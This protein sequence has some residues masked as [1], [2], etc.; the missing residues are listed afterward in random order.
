MKA[1]K[2]AVLAGAAFLMMASLAACGKDKKT[3]NE[4]DLKDMTFEAETV[5]L[6]G[7][8]GDAKEIEIMGDRLYL[9]TSQYTDTT[10]YPDDWVDG[11][12]PEGADESVW[13]GIE[14]TSVVKDSL[15]S[16]ATDGTDVK[17]L[18]T[19]EADSE[20]DGDIRSITPTASGEVIVLYARYSDS[21]GSNEFNM[22]VY[23][24]NGKKQSELSLSDLVDPEEY[25][26]G[27][28]TD[29]EDRIYLKCDQK[30]VV[31]DQEGKQLF[32]VD[33]TNYVSDIIKDKN[34]DVMVHYYEEGESQLK[35]IDVQKKG[36]GELVEAGSRV[37][38]IYGGGGDYDY[39][40]DD[41]S[42]LIGYSADGKQKTLLNWVGSNIVPNDISYLTAI[43][44]DHFAAWS[45]DEE[46]GENGSFILLKKVD[47]SK[48]GDQTAIVFGGLYL[49]DTLKKQAIK[50]NK[51]QNKYRIVL[52]DYSGEDDPEGRMNAD[53]LAGDVP[54]IL[55]LSSSPVD[56][57]ISKGMLLDLYTLIDKDPDLSR[58]DFI[59][60]ILKT[61]EVDGKL[62]YISPTFSISTLA[63]SKED[64]GD[65]KSLSIDEIKEL[66]EKHKGAKAFHS[67]Y[68]NNQVLEMLCSNNYDT[69][70][71]WKTG[72]CSF[73][74]EEFVKILEYAATYPDE[75][76]VNYDEDTDVLQDIR[77]GKTLFMQTYNMSFEDVEMYD[78]IF[79][80][81]VSFI[82]L[83]SA[84]KGIGV[85]ISS[86][87]G[88]YAK[89]PN[90]EG[91]WDFYKTLL[92]R[93]YVNSPNIYLSGLPLRKDAY[94]DA[95]KK[96]TA[97]KAYTDDFGNEIEPYNSSWGFESL[98]IDIKPLSEEQVQMMRDV[99]DAADHRVV[100][101]MEVTDI[102]TEEAGAYF[103]GAKSAKETADIIQNRI[104]TYVNENR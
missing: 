54:D 4:I 62:Y 83:P 58:D 96:A 66:E 46:L 86:L 76:K 78:Q 69:F 37:S 84:D 2:K 64:V 74:N 80:Q 50:Y 75:D 52:R 60:N 85:N 48:V 20:K 70:I 93:E 63:A 94:E 91:A 11:E 82:G 59:D 17:E 49:D 9:H 38:S 45:R 27:L 101:N 5:N 95:E 102:I 6:D 14:Y 57:Y 10:D 77:D 79:D 8:E 26:T 43:D 23:D 53:I 24:Q 61:L 44:N 99:I 13:D 35:K 100:S 98:M 42:S 104:S 88:I 81:G 12:P 47:P 56:N 15:F 31:I 36:L 67:L 25:I 40:V 34:G 16:M 3:G 51:S 39:F 68:T 97:T 55:D 90:A 103:S 19:I 87:I 33:F 72:K 73:D 22:E 1:T 30:V 71:D 18:L 29:D 89:S 65:R 92:T 32:E 41:G 7:V 21:D 28:V